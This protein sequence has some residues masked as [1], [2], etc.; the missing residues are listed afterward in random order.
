MCELLVNK[1]MHDAPVVDPKRDILLY[2]RR[3]AKFTPSVHVGRMGRVA[4]SRVNPLYRR[5]DHGDRVA[6]IVSGAL[7]KIGGDVRPVP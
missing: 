3:R 2:E 6:K 7:L 4:L 5:V 1:G